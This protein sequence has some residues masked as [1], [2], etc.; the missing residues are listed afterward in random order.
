[1]DTSPGATISVPVAAPSVPAATDPP[2][3]LMPSRLFDGVSPDAHEGWVVVTRGERIEA[4]GP[5]ASVKTPPGARI[6]DLHGAT[7]TPGLIDAHTHVLLHSYDER[8]WDDQV[9]KEPVALRIARAVNHLHAILQSGFT[10]I[11][12]LGTEGAGYADVGLRQAVEE[13]ITEGPRLLASTRA[14]VATRAYGPRGFA[15][16]LDIPQGAEEADGEGL[17]RVVR[18]QIGRG[19]D[20]V[21]IYA[22]SSTRP[23]S[24]T[25]SVDELKVAVE[26]ARSLGRPVAVHA[27]SKEGMRRAVLAGVE[28]IE[29]G[30]HAD[31]GVLRLMRQHGTALVPTLSAL[32]S[33][34]K[35]HGWHPG[36]PEPPD[37]RE[38]H[39]IFAEALRDGVAI[40][41]GSDMGVFPHGEGAH[42]IELLVRFGM[43]PA[44]ALRAATSVAAKALHLEDRVGLVRVGMLADLAAFEGDPVK[45]VAALRKVRFVMKGGAVYRDEGGGARPGSP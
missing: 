14:I 32:E 15:P 11:R 17:R 36:D 40:V 43:K 31:P 4:V 10:T 29:H 30:F 37:A 27:M 34:W 24:P 19:A 39:E 23:P 33:S 44:D 1:M 20:W 18:D 45:D 42:E 26:T 21:K 9:L 7:L 2:I 13:K 38:I 5:A 22:D 16:E 12:D 41:N 8:S 35:R 3:V 6:I 25:F 28:T